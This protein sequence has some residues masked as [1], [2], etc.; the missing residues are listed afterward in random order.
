MTTKEK[1][2]QLAA[3]FL[4]Q[5]DWY[6]TAYQSIVSSCAEFGVDPQAFTLTLAVLSPRVSVQ[7]NVR[8]AV[9]WHM[10]ETEPTVMRSVRTSFEWLVGSGYRRASIR[11][12]KTGAFADALLGDPEAVVLDVHM[13]YVLNVPH[14]KLGGKAILAEASKRI[15]WVARRLGATPR[16]AQA[17]LWCAQRESLGYPPAPVDIEAGVTWWANKLGGNQ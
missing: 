1:L 17:A 3:P 9:G 13:G 11:G 14:S 8:L 15:R 2:L 7:Q 5:S 16:E 12:P 6:Q 4:N 10:F